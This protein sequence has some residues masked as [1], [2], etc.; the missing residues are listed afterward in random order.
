MGIH[1]HDRLPARTVRHFRMSVSSGL[2]SLTATTSER[3]RAERSFWSA[4]DGAETLG[5]DLPREGQVGDAAGG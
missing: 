3:G 2:G 5:G 4:Y 1:A